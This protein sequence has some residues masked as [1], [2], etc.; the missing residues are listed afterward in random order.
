MSFSCKYIIHELQ[1]YLIVFSYRFQDNVLGVCN[2]LLSKDLFWRQLIDT[3]FWILDKILEISL[4]SSIEH[5]V[6]SICLK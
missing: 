3:G 4:L 6:S 5:P 2:L 1:D